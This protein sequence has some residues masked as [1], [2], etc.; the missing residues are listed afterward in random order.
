LRAD[1]V[2]DASGRGTLTLALLQSIGRPLPEETTIGIDLGYM[3]HASL[4][5]RT[6]PRPIGKAS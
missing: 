6:T 5:S 2:I 4:A 3:P 1:L